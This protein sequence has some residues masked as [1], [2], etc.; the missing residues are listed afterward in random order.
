MARHDPRHLTIATIDKARAAAI[1]RQQLPQTPPAW[2]QHFRQEA[3]NLE[4]AARIEAVQQ[5]PFDQ[6]IRKLKGATSMIRIKVWCEGSTDRPIFRTL[7]TELGETEIA[8][9]LDFVGRLAQ[10]PQ[11]A[12]TRTLARRLS[13]GGHYHGRRRGTKAAQEEP[14][15]KRPNQADLQRRFAS[16]PITLHVLRRYGIENYFPRHAYE[17]VLQRGMGAYFP[18]PETTAVEAH[19]CEPQPW[20]R[21]WLNRLRRRHNPSFYQKRLNEKTAQRLT[22][23]DIKGTDLASILMEVKQRAEE[24]RQF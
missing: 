2:Q 7:L 1:I 20:W 17:A 9:T 16:H 13:T 24:A 21:K 18:L 8:E 4:R 15:P 22:M 23:D 3:D 11:R 6:V 14:A 10:P 12:G 19:L 5:T